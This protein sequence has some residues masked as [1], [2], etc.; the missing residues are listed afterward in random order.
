MA[1]LRCTLV[2]YGMVKGGTRVNIIRKYE[3]EPVVISLL[4]LR[5]MSC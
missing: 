4:S 1:G 2:W 5:A 3:L